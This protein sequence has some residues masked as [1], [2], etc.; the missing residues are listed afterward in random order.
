MEAIPFVASIGR[1]NHCHGSNG[2]AHTHAP[3]SWRAKHQQPSGKGRVPIDILEVDRFVSGLL[4]GWTSWSAILP[5]SCFVQCFLQA[6]DL[7]DSAVHGVGTS[8]IIESDVD[9]GRLV[10]LPQESVSTR[11]SFS[12]RFVAP[13]FEFSTRLAE[14][15]VLCLLLEYGHIANHH[16]RVQGAMCNQLKT[17]EQFTQAA[18]VGFRIGFQDHAS[19]VWTQSTA[20]VLDDANTLL[21][22]SVALDEQN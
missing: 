16:S 18:F 12:E 11:R 6:S 19:E 3:T 13:L 10:S 21:D 4:E 17:M 1:F 9:L 15:L 22:P 20:D 5:P 2:Q 14:H 7:R 8:L